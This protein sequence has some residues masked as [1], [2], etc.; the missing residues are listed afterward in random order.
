MAT[1]TFDDRRGRSHNFARDVGIL[2][3]AVAIAFAVGRASRAFPD[4]RGGSAVPSPV[5]APQPGAA[6]PEPPWKI[7]GFRDGETAA[8]ICTDVMCNG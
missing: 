6:P 8:D 4:V 7:Q 2:L 3:L 1:Y 5:A